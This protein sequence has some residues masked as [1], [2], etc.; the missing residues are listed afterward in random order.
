MKLLILS[1]SHG[2]VFFVEQILRRER[3]AEVVIHL[4]DG[5]DDM[6]AM[7]EYTQNKAVY[8][9]RG[10]CDSSVY[11]FPESVQLN[12]EG[13]PIF[14]CHGHQFGVKFGMQKLYY[15]ARERGAKLCLFGHTHEPYSD[16]DEDFFMVNPGPAASGHYAV[17]ELKNGTVKT[18]NKSLGKL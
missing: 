17:A 10:N 8:T 3:D 9:C 12:L 16:F 13:I 5:G 15:A 11:G 18:V 14:A 4:G 2:Y 6:M 7:A 1:D